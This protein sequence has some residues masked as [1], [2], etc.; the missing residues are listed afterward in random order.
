[1]VVVSTG[2]CMTRPVRKRPY[3][4][5]G[6]HTQ[7]PSGRTLPSP[8]AYLGPADTGP[9]LSHLRGDRQSV[10]TPAQRVCHPSCCPLGLH[11]NALE[12]C[13]TTRTSSTPRV[14]PSAGGGTGARDPTRPLAVSIYVI[15]LATG[16]PVAETAPA[17]VR[18]A[19]Q[20]APHST[21]LGGMPH[22]RWSHP[23]EAQPCRSA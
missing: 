6:W 21:L 16:M 8:V 7:K 19:L 3:I 13:P 15:H 10:S 5:T 11:P 1:M 2:T 22:L 14:R 18:R 23:Q 17:R 20:R 4:R 9:V 12:P